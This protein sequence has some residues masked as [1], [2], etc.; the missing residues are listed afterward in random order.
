MNWLGNLVG[1][2][3]G[4]VAAGIAWVLMKHYHHAPG[5]AHPWIRRALAALMYMAGSA[6]AVTAVGGWAGDAA[7]WIASLFGG[8]GA[9]VA[10]VI[11]TIAA[12]LLLIGTIVG[13]AFAPDDAV[14]ASALFLPVV[15]RLPVGGA[16]HQFYVAT[17]GPA[18]LAAATVAHWLGG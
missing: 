2:G 1:S 7:G 17:T 6:L 12:F 13:V 10:W 4:L 14:I 5:K 11:I 8:H 15:L 16:L 18:Q 9:A 3:A